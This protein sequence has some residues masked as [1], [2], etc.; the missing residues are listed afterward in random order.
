MY[1][2]WTTE[3]RVGVVGLYKS[4]KT[5]LLTSLINHLQ[6][7]DPGRFRLG[8]GSATLRRFR[9]LP[10]DPGWARFDYKGHRER[11]VHAR[12]WPA[13]TT[14]RAQYVCAFERSDWR[15]RDAK[16]KLF[17]LPGERV[18]DAI[19]VGKDYAGWSDHVLDLFETDTEYRDN[20]P[21][22]LRL[23]GGAA[24]LAADEVLAAYRLGLARLVLAYKPYVCPSTFIL[25][26]QGGML[27]HRSPEGAPRPAA[28]LAHER[29]AGLSADEQFA[30]LPRA[31][32]EAD[33]ELARLFASRYQRYRAE[34]VAPLLGAIKS[35]HAL[36]VLVDVITLLAGGHGMYHDNR[37]ILIDLLEVLNPGETIL[38]RAVRTMSDVFLPH[39]WRPG[40]IT[41][42]AFVA[43][44]LDLVAPEDRDKMI[45]LVRRLT[46]RQAR[47]RDGLTPAY[48]NCSAVV[49]TDVL[50]GVGEPRY[51]VERSG[52]QQKFRVPSLPA[53]WPAQWPPLAYQFPR[54][55]PAIPPLR[56]CPPEQVNLD[57][58]F[59]F[60][61]S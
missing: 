15:L 31:R 8:D 20:C 43:P 40:W 22:Y 6:D 26:A 49:S 14:D 1:K 60:V 44:K 57:R 28:A 4:G 21:E 56:D 35:C 27:A 53:D 3:R 45:D 55:H 50:P 5:V 12:R 17:D 47:D 25:D 7:H 11:L 10:P 48:L 24:P 41:K 52:Q 18:A 32:R 36:V 23:V 16:L 38:G 51:L 59:D 13:K 29:F 33:P 9:E 37:Q 30:P 46:E 54:V 61:M 2:V 39:G 42:I 58:L 34:V 19:M